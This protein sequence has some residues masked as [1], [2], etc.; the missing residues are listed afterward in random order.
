MKGTWSAGSLAGDPEGYVEKALETGISS[1][2]GPTLGNLGESSTTGD[3]EM[4]EGGSVDESLPSLFEEALWRGAWRG[5][6]SL[7][8]LEDTFG[9]SLD[10]CISLYGSPSAARGNLVW[11]THMLV[12]LTDV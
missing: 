3:F 10:A 8:M 7:G 1:H 4:D 5:V 6:P 11:G 12:T 2:K 9:R